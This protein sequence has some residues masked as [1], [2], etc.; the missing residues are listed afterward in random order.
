M[1]SITLALFVI[2]LFVPVYAL[3][4]MQDMASGDPMSHESACLHWVGE[5]TVCPVDFSMH[6]SIWQNILFY[7]MPSLESFAMASVN[8]S[9][10][11]ILTLVFAR[12]IFYLKR[13]RFRDISLVY[14]YLFAKGILN[15]KAY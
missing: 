6:L 9:L 4:G 2:Y 10:I 7:K 12:S 14:Q 15:G 13:K 8:I 11:T 5:S 3:G 1:K